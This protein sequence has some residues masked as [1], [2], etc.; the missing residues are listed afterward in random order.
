MPK[1]SI[2][3]WSVFG[4]YKGNRVKKQPL[5]FHCPLTHIFSSPLETMSVTFLVFLSRYS[6]RIQA[7]MH[8][9]TRVHITRHFAFFT[10]CIWEIFF[11]NAIVSILLSSSM[12]IVSW[13]DCPK[14][15]QN[16]LY[17]W[18]VLVNTNKYMSHFKINELTMWFYSGCLMCL[19][20]LNLSSFLQIT[21]LPI[22]IS[23]NS[24]TWYLPF[25]DLVNKMQVL[26]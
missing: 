10:L 23:S 14:S 18:Q 19:I 3:E 12:I 11:F 4:P 2:L 22:T 24:E 9:R 7:H 8:T 21:A 13:L 1:W 6:T 20:I 15:T 25:L 5:F 26:S 17:Q 16:D